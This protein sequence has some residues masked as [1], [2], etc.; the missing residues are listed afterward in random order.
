[1]LASV[2]ALTLALVSSAHA[3]ALPETAPV[4]PA[5]LNVSNGCYF[6]STCG[7]LGA[8]GTLHDEN[9]AVRDCVCSEDFAAAVLTCDAASSCS[10]FSSVI[11]E[12]VNDFCLHIQEHLEEEH[13][14]DHETPITTTLD[15]P[16]DPTTTLEQPAEPTATTTIEIPAE[17]TTT[18]VDMP[19]PTET[20]SPLPIFPFIGDYQAP[21]SEC[22]YNCYFASTC[23]NVTPGSLHDE[24]EAVRDCVCGDAFASAVLSCDAVASCPE[25]SSGV[26]ESINDLCLHIQEHLDEEHDHDH[27]HDHETTTMAT[28]EPTPT[29][30]VEVPGESTTTLEQPAE[31]TTTTTIE[32]PAEPTTTTVDMPAPTETSSPLPIFPFIGDYQAPISECLY[33]CYFAS[34]CSNVTP[35]SLHD[36]NEAVRDC[37]C[38]DAFASAVLSC[39]A[40]ASCPEFSSGVAESINDL[41][42][43]IQEHLDEE[44]DH[45]H[46]HDH[47]TTT[48][49]TLEPTPTT[50][51]E[52]PRESTTTL[53][54]PAEPTTTTTIEIPAE[55]T[56]TTVDMPA[57][58]ETSSPLPIFPF[59][60]DYQAPISEC[61]YNCYFAS[62]C[63]NV[64][65]GSLH[66]ENEAVRDCVCGDAF[67]SAVLSCDAVASCPE[68]SSGVAES[69]NDLCLHIQEHLEEEHDHDHDHE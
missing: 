22:L 32:I 24:N 21:I 50:A 63:S 67:A 34:T 55:P 68:F 12:R 69:I 18:T 25:F 11:A 4:T 26:A 53:E 9:E 31:P 65:P 17:P 33:N 62:T 28:L 51:V 20:A 48:M 5:F 29:T 45:D 35:G 61:L 19:A 42:L 14:H 37:V 38:G 3:L 15:T 27:D 10:E 13:D 39:D 52:V 36:E 7:N 16:A 40:V 30:A 57:P 66:D 56:T 44:H 41:C 46:D 58:T 2:A 54:Q 49:A 64:T 6:A 8:S 60:G 43:H 1:M 59:I 47:E 23:S